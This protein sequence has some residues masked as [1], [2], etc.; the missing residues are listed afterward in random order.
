MESILNAIDERIVMVRL[1]SE[2]VTVT[3][4]EIYS[5]IKLNRQQN[6]SENADRFYFKL[7]GRIEK[8]FNDD[9]LLITGDLESWF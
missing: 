1:K 2:S 4:I 3:L 5:L 9:M 8:L 7:R 6:T